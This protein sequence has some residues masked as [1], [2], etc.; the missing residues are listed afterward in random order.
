MNIKEILDIFG[1]ILEYFLPLIFGFVTLVFQT[2][3]FED[4]YHKKIKEISIVCDNKFEEKLSE[5]IAL[6]ARKQ[7]ASKML[8]EKDLE[9]FEEERYEYIENL[10][11][12]ANEYRKWTTMTMTTKSHIRYQSFA[13]LLS[14]VLLVL[15]KYVP[16]GIVSLFQGVGILLFTAGFLHVSYHYLIF[17]RKLDKKYNQ[18]ELRSIKIW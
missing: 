8:T 7:E 10:L 15:S 13:F 5:Y 16:G 6:K 4:E 11:N 9:K 17:R 18:L 1:G 14:G 3:N 2:K 12:Y